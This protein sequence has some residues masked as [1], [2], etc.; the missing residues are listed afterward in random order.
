MYRVS[1]LLSETKPLEA[2]DPGGQ[3]VISFRKGDVVKCQGHYV[4]ITG[5]FMNH[6]GNRCLELG[7]PLEAKKALELQRWGLSNPHRVKLLE[8]GHHIS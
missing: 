2:G 7:V 6:A 1:G 4:V 3:E 5:M 8:S